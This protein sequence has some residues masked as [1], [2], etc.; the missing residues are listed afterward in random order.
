M[1]RLILAF[2]LVAAQAAPDWTAEQDHRAMMDRLGLATLR[3]GP[4]GDPGAP[5]AANT[6]EARANPHPDWPELLVTRAGRRVT[7]PAAWWRVRRPEIVEAFEREVYGRVPRDAPAMTWV[8]AP[9]E[10]RTIGGRTVSLERLTGRADHHRYPAIDVAI[11]AAL[12]V[13]DERRRAPV[14]IMFAWPRTLADPAADPRVAELL[15]AGWGVALLDATSI[16]ADSGAGLRRGIIGLANRGESRAPDDWGAL[17]AWGWG[18]SRLLDHLASR[19][20]VDPTRI[21]VEGV[22]RYGKAALVAAAFDTRFAMVLVGSSGAGGAKPFRRNFGEAVENLASS[23]EYHW[24]A[25]NFLRYAAPGRTAADL[26]VDSHQ[27]IA[28]VAPR[29]AF[30]SYGVPERGDAHWLDQQGS[31]MAAVAASPAWELLGARGLGVAGDYRTA[32]MPPQG[33]ALTGGALAWRQ[34]DGGHTDARNVAHFIAW[35]DRHR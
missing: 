19:R 28:L 3:P 25:G 26:P 34:H 31:Y 29:L 10:T 22:S 9:R 6:D 17:R 12:L 8:A 35:A 21:G 32:R 13:P 20:D 16:Q 24:F 30:I 15:A 27:L 23:G 1:R 4:S 2:A 33:V 7:T 14:L 11:A 5:N 18:A